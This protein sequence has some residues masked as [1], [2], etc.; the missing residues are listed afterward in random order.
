M[1]EASTTR[2]TVVVI[3]VGGRDFGYFGLNAAHSAVTNISNCEVH[4]IAKA[5][6]ALDRK[7][8]SSLKNTRIFDAEEYDL[9]DSRKAIG[10]SQ[11]LKFK[12]VLSLPQN[13]DN[14]L[15]LDADAMVNSNPF[16]LFGDDYEFGLTFR[17]ARKSLNAGVMYLR[18]THSV[19]KLIEGSLKHFEHL[20]SESGK[21]HE[22]LTREYGGLAQGAL[23]TFLESIYNLGP[24]RGRDKIGRTL[25]PKYKGLPKL[26]ILD[27]REFN[28]TGYIE[29]EKALPVVLHFKSMMRVFISQ[30]GHS[31]FAIKG[32]Q[33][34]TTRLHFEWSLRRARE[35]A[36]SRLLNLDKLDRSESLVKG[37]AGARTTA[38][39]QSEFRHLTDFL[40]IR[41]IGDKPKDELEFE[42]FKRLH[43][44]RRSRRWSV[45]FKRKIFKLLQKPGLDSP[46]IVCFKDS[47]REAKILVRSLLRHGREG[48]CILLVNSGAKAALSVLDCSEFYHSV[49]ETRGARQQII[50][51][52]SRDCDESRYLSHA[53]GKFRNSPF[54]G[55]LHSTYASA[56][57]K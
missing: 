2:K 4:V 14:I 13:G 10:F 24:L 42:L 35:S 49:T 56:L 7:L 18:N 5:L 33:A 50:I 43:K 32:A 11:V 22:Y 34:E 45:F 47:G 39:S 19:R 3:V 37:A 30:R 26:K 53:W 12:H 8:I 44:A 38:F 46:V 16:K 21:K 51:K 41:I 1:N 15:L 9:Y 48:D 17:D 27:A 20:W 36:F 28:H 23:I 40:E 55:R 25:A 29:T 6:P 31:N 57:R 54:S 52:S